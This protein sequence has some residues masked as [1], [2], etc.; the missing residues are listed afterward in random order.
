MSST[1]IVLSGTQ[2]RKKGQQ[3]NGVAEAVFVVYYGDIGIDC[4]VPDP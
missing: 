3:S 4:N 1:L 2:E